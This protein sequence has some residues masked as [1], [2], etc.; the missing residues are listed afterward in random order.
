[1]SQVIQIV[2]SY[3]RTGEDRSPAP[4]DQAEPV[5]NFETVVAAIDQRANYV[6]PVLEHLLQLDRD[7]WPGTLRE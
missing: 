6:G 4:G 1:M 2:T 7:T 5:P 3:R